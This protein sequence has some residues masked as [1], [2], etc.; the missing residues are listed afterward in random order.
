MPYQLTKNPVL[1]MD[2]LYHSTGTFHSPLQI[3]GKADSVSVVTKS[4]TKLHPVLMDSLDVQDKSQ[5]IRWLISHL[6]GQP[7]RLH[8]CPC[9]PETFWPHPHTTNRGISVP[10]PS[11]APLG[12]PASG[13]REVT[14]KEIQVNYSGIQNQCAKALSP[15][16]LRRRIVAFSPFN[17]GAV[18]AIVEVTIIATYL[19]AVAVI[20]FIQANTM[21][22]RH[23]YYFCVFDMSQ[24]FGSDMRPLAKPTDAGY[25]RDHQVIGG[26]IAEFEDVE[27]E[28]AVQDDNQLM[29]LEWVGEF[30]RIGGSLSIVCWLAM[31]TSTAPVSEQGLLMLRSPCSMDGTP[32]TT[33]CY[34][35]VSR[36]G[37]LSV[38]FEDG[39]LAF[40][41][42]TILPRVE[43]MVLTGEKDLLLLN[44]EHEIVWSSSG[45]AVFN[46]ID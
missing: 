10:S 18:S 6:P 21:S 46:C 40:R 33:E 29:S 27:L 2:Q 28:D 42:K 7:S 1:C 34:I 4:S 35:L 41:S 24:V 32:T 14:L 23:T 45:N 3:A 37:E 43:R 31:F 15:H 9:R 25:G 5:L 22:S 17:M 8:V 16:L 12:Q 44:E 26:A 36:Q 39:E 13:S 19:C 11:S 38:T 30:E 20:C